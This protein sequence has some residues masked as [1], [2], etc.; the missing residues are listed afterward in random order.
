MQ[1]GKILGIPLVL[2][3]LVVA[4]VLL[5]NVPMVLLNV[6]TQGELRNIKSGV[7]FVS[8]QTTNVQK[9]LNEMIEATKSAET[10]T[11][12]KTPVKTFIPTPSTTPVK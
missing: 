12:T 11:P 7:G 2:I 8:N 4:I 9:T 6:A 1:D 10:V 5:V 3:M